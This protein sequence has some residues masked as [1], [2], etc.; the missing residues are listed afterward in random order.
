MMQYQP[1]IS[2]LCRRW[3]DVTELREVRD[4]RVAAPRPEDMWAW[5][6]LVAFSIAFADII[7]LLVRRNICLL[8]L[9]S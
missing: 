8:W 9:A 2:A 4:K 6:N 3:G 1:A 7:P 5:W